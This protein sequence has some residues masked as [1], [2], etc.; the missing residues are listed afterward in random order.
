MPHPARS[1]LTSPRGRDFSSRIN[2]PELDRP[3]LDRPD[4]AQLLHAESPL[5]VWSLIVTIFGDA[6]MDRGARADPAPIWI[7]DLMALLDMLAIEAG[8]ARTNLSRLVANG[9]LEREKAGRNTFYRLSDKSRAD[10][11]IAARRIYS[12]EPATPTG[13]F[14]LVSVDRVENRAASRAKLEKVG[15]RFLAPTVALK[16]E[17]QGK[18]LPDLPD[19]TIIAMADPSRTLNEAAQD[20]WQIRE[21]DA[22]YRR[23]VVTFQPFLAANAPAPPV[24]AAFRVIAV[25]LYRRLV[26]RD[27]FLPVDAVPKDWS[28]EEARALFCALSEKWHAT[29]EH[30]F[31]EHRYRS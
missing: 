3:D 9:T 18:S 29:S 2:R 4:P 13:R 25:H 14:H 23:F 26:L 1:A 16:P 24:A 12:P 11:A 21:L 27:P 8:I 15:F 17:H 6:V 30:W 20:I 31:S 19:G 28:G 10:F 5:R 7:A 22:A